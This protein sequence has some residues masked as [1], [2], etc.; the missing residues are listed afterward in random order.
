MT[1]NPLNHRERQ[2]AA[3]SYV[4]IFG[5]VILFAKQGNPYIE[6]HAKRGLWLFLASIII[7]PI[8]VIYY[9]EFIVLVL[10]VLG[11]I[12]AATGHYHF[13]FFWSQKTGQSPK[14]NANEVYKN[15]KESLS[16]WMGEKDNE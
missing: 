12:S 14:E 10:M 1:S 4:W 6:H 9:A 5:P 15:V 2:W 11:F 13:L 16:K 7:W 8:P 3:L